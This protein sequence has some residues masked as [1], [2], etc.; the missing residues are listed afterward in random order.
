M[1]V[2]E[3]ERA[4]LSDLFDELGPGEPT[5]CTGWDTAHLLA[6]LLVRERRPDAAG[7]ILIKA[8]AR[9]T[10]R[11]MESIVQGA[12]FHTQVEQFRSGPP[13]WSPWAIPVL[14]DRGN[15]A[16]FFVHHED[17][18][19]AQPDWLPRPTDP[20]REEALWKT[21]HLTGRLLYRRAPGGVVAR[22]TGRED[23]V[24]RKGTPQ[25]VLVGTA[26][27]IVLH[28]FGRPAPLCRVVVQGDPDAITR[29]EAAPRGL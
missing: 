1:T 16:E 8:L 9:R 25:V 12:P 18:R 27:E 13:M 19:R 28:G 15:T 22:V 3:Q 21:L 10:E 5:L 7:G 17:V 6:H 11:V 26:S 4:E 14:G 24:L 23:L 20:A 2:A 29:F